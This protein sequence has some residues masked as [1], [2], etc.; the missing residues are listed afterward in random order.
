MS[1]VQET[2]NRIGSVLQAYGLEAQFLEKRDSVYKVYA[3]SGNYI[4][5][6]IPAKVGLDFVR[7]IHHMAQKGFQ[8]LV[9]VFP[10][11]DGR[12]GVLDGTT[13]Y[14]LMPFVMNE[15]L[16]E[17][18]EKMDKMLKELARLHLLS[19]KEETVSTEDREQHYQ[20]LD[21]E[22]EKESDFLETFL[23]ECEEE[24]Y[25]S[26]FQLQFLTFYLDVSQALKYAR[27]KLEQWYEESKDQEKVRTVLVHGK[28]N[29]D[30]FLF[31]EKGLGFFTSF[32]RSVYG[33]PSH[34]LLPF[35]YQVVDTP[36]KPHEDLIFALQS[37]FS[38]FPLKKEELL[39]FQAYLAHPGKL[40][41][42]VQQY[43]AKEHRRNEMKYV[44]RLQNSYWR[45]KNIEY[46]VM[47]IEEI[48]KQKEEQSG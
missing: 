32:E 13:L 24:W 35:I 2:S 9:P 36:M 7:N 43:H 21:G 42:V 18:Q 1:S 33:S 38:H 15:R 27:N 48:E 11:L 19:V 6:E 16:E 28:V 46:I 41:T 20:I 39:L 37:Y 47:R 22:W 45:L 30:H 3:R 4:L 29:L 8:R 25:P 44:Q 10:T 12:Y 5:K 34:D 14:Y 31:D 26:P 40:T 23:K 17:R